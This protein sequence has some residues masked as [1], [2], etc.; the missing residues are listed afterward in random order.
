VLN[1]VCLFIRLSVLYIHQTHKNMLRILILLFLLKLSSTPIFGQGQA[2]FSKKLK[3]GFL[4]ELKENDT[5]FINN[6]L[7]GCFI[8]SSLK[9]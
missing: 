6:E 3:S 1:S 2:F 8:N 9:N 5:L 7:A 4:N